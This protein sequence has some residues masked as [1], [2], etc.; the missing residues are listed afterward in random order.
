MAIHQFLGHV[1]NT[2]TTGT[3]RYPGVNVNQLHDDQV[4]DRFTGMPVYNGTPC[5]VEAIKG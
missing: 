4:R 3:R 1:Y 2:G 5:Q